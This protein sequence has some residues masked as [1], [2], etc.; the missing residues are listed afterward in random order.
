MG[1]EHDLVTPLLKA[2]APRG[3]SQGALPRPRCKEEATRDTTGKID[4]KQNT[5]EGLSLLLPALPPPRS[6]AQISESKRERMDVNYCP[7]PLFCPSS[8][9][10]LAPQSTSKPPAHRIL[11]LFTC[12]TLSVTFLSHTPASLRTDLCSSLLTGILPPQSRQWDILK[13]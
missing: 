7:W 9:N 12:L 13:A 1:H 4:G 10:E 5:R 6:F 8:V 11:S 3:A 2:G